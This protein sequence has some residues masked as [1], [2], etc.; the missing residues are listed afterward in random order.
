MGCTDIVLE[1]CYKTQDSDDEDADIKILY[2]D[3]IERT[4]GAIT[5]DDLL[6]KEDIAALDNP[7]P[8]LVV[9]VGTYCNLKA[10]YGMKHNWLA[11]NVI[12]IAKGY[13]VGN[14]AMVRCKKCLQ[15]I[16]V[17]PCNE[18]RLYEMPSTLCAYCNHQATLMSSSQWAAYKRMRVRKNFQHYYVNED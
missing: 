11:Y 7:V 2:A 10:Y 17:W 18:K 13:Y 14:L 1:D 5:A 4:M 3:D 12:D 6:C 15:V 8:E 9:P 16:D